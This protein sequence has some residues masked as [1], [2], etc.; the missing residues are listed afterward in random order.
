MSNIQY[1]IADADNNIWVKLD[2]LINSNSKYTWHNY[3]R[4]SAATGSYKFTVVKY[5]SIKSLFSSIVT[6]LENQVS[7]NQLPA[8][9]ITSGYRP[10]STGS[11]HGDYKGGGAAID[12]QSLDRTS[13]GKIF[14]FLYNGIEG[15]G[16]DQ[17]IWERGVPNTYTLSPGDLPPSEGGPANG[18][19]AL[20]HISWNDPARHQTFVSDTNGHGSKA[21]PL[22]G[23]SSASTTS[24]QEGITAGISP[25]TT[26]NN[27]VGRYAKTMEQAAFAISD[28]E[29]NESLAG[30]G[31]GK[32]WTDEAPRKYAD[33]S[34]VEIIDWISLKQYLLYLSSRYI[35]SSFYPFI[36]MIPISSTTQGGIEDID[37]AQGS[38]Q[39]VGAT[40]NIVNKNDT[41]L[42]LLSQ[43][44]NFKGNKEKG[45][46]AINK[47]ANESSDLWRLDP[48]REMYDSMY[49]LNKAGQEIFNRR[50]VGVRAYGQ[51][52]LNPGIGTET[53]SKPGPIGFTKLEIDAGTQAENGLA[54][55]TMEL[56]DVQGNKFTD[57]SS[58]W[59]WIYDS[60]PG[61]I[62]GDFWLRY[63][64]QI[65]L[66]DPK[67]FSDP[68][69]KGF[70]EHEGWNLFGKEVKQFIMQQVTP[71]TPYITLTQ[72]V[73]SQASEVVGANGNIT[74]GGHYALFD[75]GVDYDSTTGEVTVSNR[76]I[77]DPLTA[78]NNYVRVSILNPE[79][80]VDENGA[81][82]AT[83]SFRTTGALATTIPIT[84]ANSL[85]YLFFKERNTSCSLAD[86]ILATQIDIATFEYASI[87]DPK[88][89]AQRMKYVNSSF[90]KRAQNEGNFD[91][92]VTVVGLGDGGGIGTTHPADVFVQISEENRQMLANPSK[93]NPLTVVG[94]IRR[95]LNDNGMELSSVA[96]GS[97]AG[98][99]AAWIITV[100]PDFLQQGGIWKPKQ[101]TREEKRPV[102]AMDIIYTEP[103][104]FSFRFQ[105][106][107]VENIKIEKTDGNNA[108][109]LGADYAIADFL[110]VM[111]AE[112]IDS[113]N[114]PG[115]LNQKSTVADRRRNLNII[116]AQLQ[117]V[118]VT[119]LC[120][121]WIG[122]GKNFFIK[123]MGLFDGEYKSLRVKHKWDQSARW[124]SEIGGARMILPS[125]KEEASNAK[126]AA[127][128]NGNS[129]FSSPVGQVSTP[130]T[131]SSAQIVGAAGTTIIT[132]GLTVVNENGQL[133]SAVTG[134]LDSSSFQMKNAFDK[135]YWIKKYIPNT[136]ALDKDVQN[137][138]D[139][140][141]KNNPYGVNKVYN[142][143]T[144]ITECSALADNFYKTVGIEL[145]TYIQTFIP[146][147]S[148]AWLTLVKKINSLS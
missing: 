54:L 128:A 19:P 23:N 30:W 49:D 101:R 51:L 143:K 142:T 92:F 71:A 112:S 108:L 86:L 126:S 131:T 22:N 134:Q 39:R 111:D 114:Q 119:C 117:N 147:T 89:K 146:S 77:K 125:D 75:E 124:I 85:R 20:I 80:D 5:A 6:V 102:D 123:G 9:V 148:A 8:F 90:L 46:D 100:G 16:I 47:S 65:R 53:P 41:Q 26:G 11:Q 87:Q 88:E 109:K 68:A 73:S 24:G 105:G 144:L 21:R 67:D 55:I 120:H 145:L 107:L 28:L 29:L 104:V 63:G 82:K 96:T 94:W 84:N 113:A 115:G 15:L 56:I 13:N 136:D 4:G 130:G 45:I 132:P 135:T 33:G 35:A 91:N 83:L 40:S 133:T 118:T 12:I 116:Y 95:V 72:S 70:W 121:P 141:Q 106:T 76:I 2:D 50:N 66:P 62:G 137:I 38:D 140:M 129:N 110:A 52:V 97:G 31:S 17:L 61:S 34:S 98:I 43:Q 138:I 57:L 139:A 81:I 7:F 122:P 78:Y 48:Y 103:D 59:S 36:E 25:L 93:D 127:Q 42:K 60:R 37:F 10:E 44:S 79:L 18:G 69:A 27:L 1:Y 32:N 3:I 14:N 99:N 58:P 64:W 74:E